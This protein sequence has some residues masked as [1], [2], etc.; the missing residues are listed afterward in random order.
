MDGNAIGRWCCRHRRVSL[1]SKMVPLIVYC[2]LAGWVTTFPLDVVKTRMQSTE[3][4][5]RNSISKP[6][7]RSSPD[8]PLLPPSP[9][10]YRTVWSTIVVSYQAEGLA[11]FFRG[12]APTLIRA[13]PVNMATF[14]TFEAVIHGFSNQITCIT[15]Y[16]VNYSSAHLHSYSR[17]SSGKQSSANRAC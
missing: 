12:L 8:S 13:V 5:Y 6:N 7:A 2:F 14:A 17:H 10:R 15:C 4:S 1:R 16:L 9:N 3:S 11:V